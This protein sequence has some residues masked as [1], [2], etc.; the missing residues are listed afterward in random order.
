VTPAASGNTLGILGH[1]ILPGGI[2]QIFAGLL[3]DRSFV[4]EHHPAHPPVFE[5]VRPRR[6]QRLERPERV[7]L[8]SVVVRGQVSCR[9]A[10]LDLEEV[11]LIGQ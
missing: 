6:R 8:A 3:I 5:I 10:A 7:E 9:I 11:L 1:A 4:I 2:E